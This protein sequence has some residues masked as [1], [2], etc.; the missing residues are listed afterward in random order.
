MVLG[1]IVDCRHCAGDTAAK[2]EPTQQDKGI[3]IARHIVA[4]CWR[5]IAP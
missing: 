1:S 5:K 2:P 4:H 3:N